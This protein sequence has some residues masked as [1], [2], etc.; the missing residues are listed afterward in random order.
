MS[1]KNIYLD[2]NA[3]TPLDPSVAETMR[4]YAQRALGNPASQ[5]HAG[6]AARSIL[7]EAREGILKILGAKT[8]GMETDQLLF[9]SG[10][11]EANNLA[12][13]GLL[14]EKW[15]KTAQNLA[16]SPLVISPIEH[17]SVSTTIDYITSYDIPIVKLPVSK[18]GRVQV[19][20]HVREIF[21]KTSSAPL[22]AS[23]MLGNN[24]TGVLQPVEEIAT[25]CQKTGTPIHTDAVQVVGKQPVHFRKLQVS[26][27]SF[28]AHKFHGPVGIGGLIVRH[29]TK[30][31]PLLFGGHQQTDLRPGTESVVLAVGMHKALKVYKNSAFER[32]TYLKN[33]QTYF[34][35]AICRVYPQAVILGSEEER[36]PHTSNVALVGLDRQAVMMALDFVGVACSTGSACASGSSEPS[37]VLLAMDCDPSHIKSA[38]RFSFGAT[39]TISELDLAIKRISNVCNSLR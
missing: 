11:T 1:D 5:H 24:E 35:R 36:L 13:R 12:L 32:E 2:H 10:G 25:L 22:L 23:L 38:I 31:Q 37:P 39:Q 14:P 6:R 8:T 28:S 15:E 26:T 29:K 9:T 17:P 21:S 3:T 33:L 16:A 19:S 30:L 4:E 34:E 7:E 27:L 18:T 20:T